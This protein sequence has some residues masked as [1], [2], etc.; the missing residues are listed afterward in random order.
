MVTCTTGRAFSPLRLFKKTFTQQ[1]RV[2]Y[3]HDDIMA[4][5]RATGDIPVTVFD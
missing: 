4:A 1:E 2:T 3:S 5:M